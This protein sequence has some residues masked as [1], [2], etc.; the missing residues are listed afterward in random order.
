MSAFP[1]SA[2][3]LPSA[4]KYDLPPSMSDTA[5]SYSVNVAPDGITQVVGAAGNIS[6]TANAVTQSQF[7]SQVVSFTIPSG[8]SDSVFLDC[9]NTTVSFTLTY[10]VGTAASVTN[11]RCKLLSN[12][13]SW[14]DTLVLY[15]NNTPLETVNQYGLLQNFLLQNTVSL[16][17]RVGGVSIC[18]GTD[19]N[20]ASGIDLPVAAGS[21]RFNF[22]IPLISLI[23]LNTE[24]YFPIGSVNNMQL[25]MT[26]ANLCPI[27]TYCTAVATNIALTTAP[28]LNEFRLNLKYLD[29]GDVAS[30]MLRQTLQDGKWYIKSSTYTNSAVTLPSGS[31][32]NQQA[33]LQIR[34]SSVK[35]VFH[36][37]GQS[38]AVTAQGLVSPNGAYDAINIGTTSRQLQ[39]GGAYFPNLPINDVQR[40][41]EGYAVLIQSLG[42]AIP[43]A[44]GTAVTREMYNSVGG[45][46]AVPTGADNGLVLP[47]TTSRDAPAGSNQGALS[48]IDYPSGAFYGYDLEKVGG[49][50][51]SGLNT[52]AAPPFLNLFLGSA[53][54][55]SVTTQS[56][57]LSDVVMVVDTNSKSV[58]A[59][60]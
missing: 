41:A 29:V 24:K 52:R 9:M 19:A 27:I 26:T 15:S 12:A 2:M 22:C 25:Q 51:F 57:G 60:I 38:N 4:L 49:V 3:G 58:Q 39:V 23:G 37:F 59:F 35:S 10:T 11:G 13:A 14:F 53:L 40:P 20:S 8:M 30:A 6:F 42:G 50:L 18:M 47:A 48:V 7:S 1:A 55:A 21:Y 28:T 45:I 16:S 46:A 54:N 33:L 44:Y 5:R 31:A 43:K 34:N 17:E 32:G 36:Q 56:W